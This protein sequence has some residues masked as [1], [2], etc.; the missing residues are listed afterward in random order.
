MKEQNKI[1]KTF[2][3]DKG[4]YDKFCLLTDKLSVNKSKFVE[5]KIKEFIAI[6]HAK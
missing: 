5:N 3:L 2:T 1:R 6:N 4:L